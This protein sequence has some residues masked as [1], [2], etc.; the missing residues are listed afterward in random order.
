MLPEL[1]EVPDVP[2]NDPDEAP[3]EDGCPNVKLILEYFAG[4]V[5]ERVEVR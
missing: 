4:L 5:L 2:N 1:P 3:D